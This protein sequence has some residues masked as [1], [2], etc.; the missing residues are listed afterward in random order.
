MVPGSGDGRSSSRTR[1]SSSAAGDEFYRSGGSGSHS[2]TL[3]AAQLVAVYKAFYAGVVVM[4]LFERA[5]C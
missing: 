4:A 1:L 2:G 3:Y 5:G